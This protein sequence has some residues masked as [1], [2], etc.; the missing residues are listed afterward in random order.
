MHHIHQQKHDNNLNGRHTPGQTPATTCIY[1]AQQLGSV[2]AYSLSSPNISRCTIADMPELGIVNR[3]L[4]GDH[5][6]MRYSTQAFPGTSPPSTSFRLRPAV[7]PLQSLGEKYHCSEN[8]NRYVACT[9]PS[10]HII[11]HHTHQ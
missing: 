4:G 1:P 5:T 10:R 2:Q 11:N 7:F 6:P 9:H 8:V 3:I